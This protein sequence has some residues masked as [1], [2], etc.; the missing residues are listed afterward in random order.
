MDLDQGI[1][2]NRLQ[3]MLPA[4][5]NG[6]AN[7]QDRQY[8]KDAITQSARARSALAWHEALAEKVIADIEAVPAD[9]GWAQL[10]ARVRA[11]SQARQLH[12]SQNADGWWHALV[13]TL[14]S[15]MPHNW[16]S[17]PVLSSVCALLLAVLGLQQ[18]IGS[19]S[20]DREYSQVRGNTEAPALRP[21]APAGY[22][23]VKL[24][25]KERISERDMRLLLI[26]TGAVL[27]GGPGQ[28]GDYT[29][30]VPANQIESVLKEFKSSALT[31]SIQEITVSQS[32]ND[33]PT[34]SD[35][36]TDPVQAMQK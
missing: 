31:E 17:G 33:A 6:T 14:E 10:Q 32:G 4:Y 24:N 19:T 9:I 2:M 26:R 35:V 27:V 18:F 23:Y 36:G 15:W 13:K 30:A 25:F 16:V 20:E 8:V 5:V 3:A 11:A 34:H 12:N 1:N 7:A 21:S 28:L 22:K 29:V